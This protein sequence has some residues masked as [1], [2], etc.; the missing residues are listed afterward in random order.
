MAGGVLGCDVKV[1]IADTEGL[2]EKASA[3]MEKLITQEE[4][5]KLFK[6]DQW[7]DVTIRCEGNHIQHYL[8]GKLIL[9][10]VDNHPKALLDGVL[11]LQ[12]HAGAPMW[13]EF[14]DIRIAELK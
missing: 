13:T 8:N 2:P 5:A 1:I 12:L 9:D 4:Y 3:I 11:A 14:K 6:L 10:F 7:N